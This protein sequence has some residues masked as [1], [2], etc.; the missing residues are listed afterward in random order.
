M[1]DLESRLPRHVLRLSLKTLFQQPVEEQRLHK[2][3]LQE[4]FT[5]G[6]V[7]AQAIVSKLNNINTQSIEVAVD[8][9]VSSNFLRFTHGGAVVF[10][11]RLVKWA[12][13]KNLVNLVL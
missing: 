5:N 12:F 2:F 1:Y 13:E 9:L 6:E 7:E 3:I 8:H 4:V 11:R 10:H